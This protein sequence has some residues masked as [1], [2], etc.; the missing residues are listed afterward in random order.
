[1]KAMHFMNFSGCSNDFKENTKMGKRLIIDRLK[2][3]V[4]Y[5]G[6]DEFRFD[7]AALLGLKLWRKLKKNSEQLNKMSF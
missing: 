2:Y 3:W 1:M 5:F 6:V 7:L 4:E